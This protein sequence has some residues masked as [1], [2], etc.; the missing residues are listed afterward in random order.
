MH[1][2][3]NLSRRFLE[4]GGIFGTASAGN[5]VA[6]R[7]GFGKTPGGFLHVDT[8]DIG[9]ADEPGKNIPDFVF[10]LVRSAVPYGLGKLTDFFNEP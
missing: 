1:S 9:D 3:V 7:A 8:G 4:F 10:D 6:I 2:K 5:M